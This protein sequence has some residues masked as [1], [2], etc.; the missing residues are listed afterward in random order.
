MSIKKFIKNFIIEQDENLVQVSPDEYL[1]TLENVGGVADRVAKLKPYRGKGIVITGPINLSGK[2]N[3]GPLTGV[4]RIMGRLD[5]SGS[6][7]PTLDGITVDGYVSDY[8]S[9]MWRTKKQKE[10]NEKLDSLDEKRRT[11]EWDVENGDDESERTEAL[12]MYLDSTGDIDTVESDDGGTIREDKYYIYPSGGGNYGYG[13][14][15]EWLGGGGGFDPKMYVVYHEDE[16][17]SAAKEAIGGLIDDIGYG[18]F[19]DWVWEDAIDDKYWEQWLEEFFNDYIYGDP[20][21]FDIP[22][23]LSKQQETQ[24]SQ[25]NKSIEVLRNK[26]K[27]D[28]L[29]DEERNK[30]IVKITGLE[31]IIKEINEDPEGDSYDE[32]AIE[33]EV[34]G[35]VDDYK[36]DIKRFMDDFGYESDRDFITNFIDTSKLTETVINSDGYGSVLNSYDGDYESYNINGSEYYVMRSS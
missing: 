21:S 5:I 16:V 3:I 26:I 36:D 30:I 8:G 18:A 35:R 27:N 17:D 19:P 29:T 32:D 22:L 24:V 6:N 34:G 23:T 4:V 20:E 14:E 11:D 2:K 13:R 25:L 1:E 7:I 9:T 10:L 28:V 12:Y 31:Q 15:Y 33:R